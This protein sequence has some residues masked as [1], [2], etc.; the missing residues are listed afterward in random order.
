M[1][2]DFHYSDNWA[3]PGHQIKPKAW[4]NY[5]HEELTTAVYNYTRS[6]IETLCSVG[7]VPAAVQVG[8]DS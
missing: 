5:S 6:S 4:E 7:A 1:L 8:Y 3:D 2:I